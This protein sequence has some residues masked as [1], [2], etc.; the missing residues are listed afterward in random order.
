VTLPRAVVHVLLLASIV[1][2]AL[3]GVR[4]FAFFGG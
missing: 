4:V 3:A 2:G 1:L